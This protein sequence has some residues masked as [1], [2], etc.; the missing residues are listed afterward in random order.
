[1]YTF[2]DFF[3]WDP[4]VVKDICVKRRLMLEDILRLFFHNWMRLGPFWDVRAAIF[5]A[6][7]LLLAA[8]TVF[9]SVF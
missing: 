7:P 8:A 4:I 2:Y 3:G 9:S 1:L 5:A 6:K